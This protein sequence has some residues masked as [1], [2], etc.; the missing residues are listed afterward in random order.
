MSIESGFM[1]IERGAV[2]YHRMMSSSRGA[3]CTRGNG[4]R[5]MS[6]YWRARYFTAEL[7]MMEMRGVGRYMSF[8]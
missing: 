8:S 5:C 7:F 4:F 3:A 2:A 6:R 1:S